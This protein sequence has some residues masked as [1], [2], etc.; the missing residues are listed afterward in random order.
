ML[1]LNAP[2]YDRSLFINYN[3]YHWVSCDTEFSPETGEPW[4]IQWSAAPGTASMCLADDTQQV[5]NVKYLLEHPETLTIMHN[6][7]ADLPILWKLGIRPSN[8]VCTM[9]ALYNLGERQGLKTAAF[10]NCGL[11]MKSYSAVVAPARREKALVWTMGAI[12]AGPYPDPPPEPVWDNG[13]QKEKLYTEEWVKCTKRHKDAV[14]C[15]WCGGS[16]VRNSSADMLVECRGCDGT[17]YRRQEIKQ[18]GFRIVPGT[19]R[20]HWR[21]KQPQNVARSLDR[22]LAACLN[23][24]DEGRT[25]MEVWEA[26]DD[27]KK[28][29]V[30]HLVG[31]MP[32]ASLADIPIQ[33]A[34][35]YG[36]RDADATL[37]LFHALLP[38]IEALG[39]MD[40]LQVDCAVIPM[41]LEME[42]NGIRID[43]AHFAQ[44]SAYYA[45]K[46][47]DIDMLIAITLGVEL[48]RIR[49]TSDAWVAG[50][51]Y[52]ELGLPCNKHSKKTKEPSVDAEALNSIIDLHPVVPLILERRGAEKFKG[53]YVDALP[54]RM[55]KHHRVHGTIKNTRT[56][57]G[58]ISMAEP[59]LTN[60]PAQGEEAVNYLA[61]FLARDGYVFVKSD[62]SGI[63]LR[64]MAHVSR[65]AGLL[66]VFNS[67]DDDLHTYKAMEIWSLD[68]ATAKK[69][70]D[71]K[72]GKPYRFKAKKVNFGIP[73][74]IGAPGLAVQIGSSEQDA[75]WAIDRWFDTT[76]GMRTWTDGVHRAVQST[77][78]VQEAILG[79]I[80]F[81]PEARAAA[82]DIASTGLREAGNAPIQGGAQGIIKLAMANMMRDRFYVEYGA[83][84]ILQIHDALLF[85]CPEDQA[86]MF[87]LELEMRMESAVSLLVPTPV[88]TAIGQRWSDVK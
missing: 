25:P 79:R 24:D 61:G 57:T 35:E 32:L 47:A 65:D 21:T 78:F 17:G 15:G 82:K 48:D 66:E 69:G 81:I 59:N 55:D 71:P 60:Q 4:S 23:S 6:S 2:L 19:E 64:V 45:N 40:C 33:D 30:E 87:A 12:A 7:K 62:Y 58:R 37:R 88:D 44:L 53:T 18:A 1:L 9:V 39:L 16:K 14:I 13:P 28:P 67:E 77:G 68:Y 3:D 86:D 73:Y 43:P 29:A 42:M 38:R 54:P 63:E 27:S 22:V 46:L 26:V 49:P 72:D 76:P 70:N 5:A 74:G 10:R 75:K 36:C 51:L 85:E 80:R 20:G 41:L 50:L 84:P 31:A 11:E 52:G 83:R 56:A 8:T 34:V